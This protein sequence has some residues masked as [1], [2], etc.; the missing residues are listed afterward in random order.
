M[1]VT[2]SEP[3]RD[4]TAVGVKVTLIVHE[5]LAARLVPQVLV[6]EKSPVRATLEI[7]SATLLVL[8][9]VRF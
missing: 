2:V 6:S 1:S 9:R 5:E 3:V 7:V 4:P 8:E